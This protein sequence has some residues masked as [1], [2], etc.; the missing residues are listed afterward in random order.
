[1]PSQFTVRMVGLSE[2]S[3]TGLS[4]YAR[5][6]YQELTRQ[7]VAVG[8]TEFKNPPIPSFV[9][10]L[11]FDSAKFFS[12]FPVALPD[13]V[14]NT[15]THL[16][17]QNHASAVVFKKVERLVVTVHD[18][19]TLCYNHYPEFTTHL[20]FYDKFFNRLA[21]H[22]LKK[23]GML[24]ADSE[25]TRQDIIRHLAYPSDRIKVVY[26]GVNHQ[27]FRVKEVPPNFYQRY[28]LREDIPYLLNV[29]SE[30]PRKNIRRLLAAF[31]M[32]ST[33]LP[34]VR[35]LKVG[36]AEF[37]HERQ[38]LLDAARQLGISDKVDFFDRVSDT[39]L[40]YFYNIATAFV[41]PS[42]YEGFGLPALEAMA[43]GIPVI[44]SNATSLPEVVG[45]AALLFSPTDTVEMATLIKWVLSEPDL[46]KHLR[47][48]SLEQ[49][50]LF[51]WEKTAIETAKIYRQVVELEKEASLK[52]ETHL[53]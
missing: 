35:L 11:G 49:A 12:T 31:A 53:C 24:I 4:R 43:C 48:L 32:V 46:Q 1:M 38:S 6:L 17:T 42:L 3:S 20:K 26:A 37:R 14:G 15:V 18:L 21:A 23:A 27:N 28:N 16:T 33:E 25:Y 29:G 7:G 41:F 45:D 13:S 50:A 5:S 19:I 22:G 36:A 44:C 51:S 8:L 40:A 39:D 52:R 2:G 10:K 30:D 34:A 47:R 9:G